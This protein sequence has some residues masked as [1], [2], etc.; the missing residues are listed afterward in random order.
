[1]TKA[2]YLSGLLRREIIPLVEGDY[3]LYGLP[4]YSNIGDTLI[5]EGERSLLRDSA[6]KCKGV[7]GWNDYPGRRLKDDTVMLVQG[8]GYFGDVWRNAWENV[9]REIS[10]NKER[11]II[12]LPVSVWYD[13]SGLLENDKRLLSSAKDLVIC[14]RDRQSFDFASKHFDNDIRLVPDAAFGI[15]PEALEK[16]RLP[17]EKECLYL[18]R[19]DKEFIASD[20]RIPDDAVVSD[21]PTFTDISLPEKLVKRIE[22]SY[23]RHRNTPVLAPALR[24]ATDCAFLSVYRKQMISRGVGF[25]SQY[26]TVY[27]TRLHGLILAALLGKQAYC[28]DNSYGKVGSFYETWL[29]DADNIIAAYE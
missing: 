25:I 26:R 7:C 18:K 1:M 11:R 3:V 16:W 2:K 27:T 21:W 5:W 17:E 20:A 10:L 4:Y 24:A 29:S 13:D 19:N 6:F 8:G 9:L 28:L 22:S 14:V 15:A 23:K 12:I